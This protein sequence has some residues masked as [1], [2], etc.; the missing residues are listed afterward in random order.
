MLLCFRRGGILSLNTTEIIQ[1]QTDS[2]TRMSIEDNVINV[3]VDIDLNGNNITGLGMST[4][5]SFPDGGAWTENYLRIGDGSSI[6]QAGDTFSE[7]L[8]IRTEGNTI[9][10]NRMII[11]TFEIDF[12][13][14][15]DMNDNDILNVGNSGG[16]WTT[17]SLSIGSGDGTLTAGGS[18]LLD[19]PADQNIDILENNDMWVRYDSSLRQFV[20]RDNDT[21][22]FHIDAPDGNIYIQNSI[23]GELN[24]NVEIHWEDEGIDFLVAPEGVLYAVDNTSHQLFIIDRRT[25]MATMVHDTNTL[26]SEEYRSLAYDGTNLYSVSTETDRLYIIDIEESTSSPVHSTNTITGTVEG[27][28]W[29]GSNMY[30]VVVEGDLIRINL[31]NGDIDHCWR[32]W[33]G[34]NFP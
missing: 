2:N 16:D 6:L 1:L 5:D 34:H 8:T 12:F 31:S 32:S 9:A 24:N 7:S 29:D 13:E 28:A 10:D 27:M 15:L 18:L 11:S 25:G 30:A 14:N 23:L 22:V 3:N 19:V 4:G 26:M 17:N 20:I 33:C 21:T